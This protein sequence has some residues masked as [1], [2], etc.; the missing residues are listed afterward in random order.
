MMDINRDNTE[1]GTTQ[2]GKKYSRSSEI[3]ILFLLFSLGIALRL[4]WFFPAVLDWDESTFILMGQSILDGY[5]PY[6]QLWDLKPPLAFGFFALAIATFG[7]SIVGVRLAGTLCVVAT[8]FLIYLTAKKLWT[9]RTGVFAAMLCIA[10]M[11]QWPHGQAT[12]T[13]LVSLVPLVGALCLLVYREPT[14][15]TLFH[16]GILMATSSLVRLNLGYVAVLIGFYAL[17]APP[18]HSLKNLVLRSMSYAGGGLLVVTLTWIP[19]LLA[20]QQEMWWT[21]VF[22]APLNYADSQFSVFQNLISQTKYA[23]GVYG[24]DQE[25]YVIWG[26]LK[27]LVRGVC[28]L[29]WLGGVAGFAVILRQWRNAVVSTRRASG[30]VMLFLVGTGFSIL[31]S[32]S[33][34]PDYMLQLIPFSALLAAVFFEKAMFS[35]LRWPVLLTVAVGV[36]VSVRDFV[37]GYQEVFSRALEKKE[38]RYGAAYEIAEYLKRENKH[39][40]PVYMLTDHIAYW[41]MGSYPLTRSTTHPSNI[42]RLYLLETIVGKGATVEDELRRVLQKEPEF[43]VTR[44]YVWYLQESKNAKDLLEETLASEYILVKE[45]EGRKIYRKKRPEFS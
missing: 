23:L 18:V 14:S 25:G 45:I 8:A 13:E 11:S 43:I 16:A 3:G 31:K 27:F 42:A 4:P 29:V 33:A 20:G 6:V 35:R 37:P 32:G 26:R 22:L 15:N 38:L 34:N 36:A 40:R 17:L 30:L 39:H 1:S 41:F 2:M 12:L 7:K 19:Y 44:D 10:A 28:L 9:R 5:L 21:S 24:I